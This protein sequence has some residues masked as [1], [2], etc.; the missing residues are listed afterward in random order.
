MRD[1]LTNFLASHFQLMMGSSKSYV[2]SHLVLLRGESPDTF[3]HV[4]SYL[5]SVE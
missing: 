4:T 2:T 1:G 5:L 3:T